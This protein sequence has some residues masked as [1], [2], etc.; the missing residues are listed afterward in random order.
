[1]GL[2]ER[3][4]G[5][6]R[7]AK[8]EG[9]P[10]MALMT[11]S[12]VAA[13]PNLRYDTYVREGYQKNELVFACVEEWCTDIAEPELRVYRNNADDDAEEVKDHPAVALMA[14]PNPFMSGDD[15]LA[16][17]ELYKRI[18]GNAYEL[19]VRS[20]GMKVVEKWLL[21]PDRVVIVPSR[22]KH[23][24]HYE[25]RIGAEKYD[26]DPLD[27]IHHRTRNPYDD[28]YGMPPMM[29]LSGSADIFNFMK[30]M[31]KGFLQ[32]SGM[33]AGI[34]SVA[35]KMTEGEKALL[36]SRF[37][38]EF[39]GSNTGNIAIADGGSEAASFVP[40]SMPLG[41]RGLI[42]PELDE[43]NEARIC[44]VFRMPL[45][46]AGA[47]LAQ[48]HST[49]G[50]AGR[51]ADRQFFT[52]QELVPEW[53]SIASTE[54]MGHAEDLLAEGEFFNF[55]LST[56]RSLNENEDSRTVRILSQQK[57]LARSIQETRAEFGLGDP[58]PDDLFPVPI[59]I[60]IT[61]WADII[62]PP[63]PVPA[64]MPPMQLP[65]GNP[66]NLPT[67]QQQQKRLGAPQVVVINAQPGEVEKL[68]TYDADGNIASVVEK[69]R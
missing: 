66:D 61:R 30:D 16:G 36:R 50:Q 27:V 47:R 41:T 1:M 56:V 45:S 69:K 17:I 26:L 28:Y 32:N 37:R 38:N 67:T 2:F 52:E 63:E 39:G 11:P 24:D 23:I 59:N 64:P 13:F 68:F 29:P 51:E 25:Y 15:F 31:V 14:Q 35:G 58:K 5:S 40:L 46:L 20:Q 60:Q 7:S 19:K 6:L 65:P 9:H 42:V 3:T 8:A 43:M 53:K 49:L 44:M 18:A 55:D 4:L 22:E 10:E 62:A 34:L 21:R 54:T 57:E 12:G 48:V 33:P